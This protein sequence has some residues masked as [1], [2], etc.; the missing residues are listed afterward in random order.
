MTPSTEQT[1]L[2][3]G[4]WVLALDTPTLPPAT[5]TNTLIVGGDRL[6]I[7]E[8]ATPHAREQAR[9]DSL[10]ATLRAEGRELAGVLVTHH[11]VDHVGYAEGLRDAHGIPIYAH[12][13]TASRVDFAVDHELE[14]DWTIDLGD[15][16]T[17]ETIH[18]PG[19]APGHVVVWDQKTG[20]VHAGDLVAGQ[21]TILI[22]VSD[23][24]D[25]AVYLD[26]LRRMAA[27]VGA[28]APGSIRFVPA[29][30]PVLDDPLAV[31]EHYIR[32]RLAREAKVRAAVVEAGHRA[33]M[34]IFAAAYADT[35][36]RLWPFAALSLEAHL[37][38]LVAD[39]ELT[40]DGRGAKPV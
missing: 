3:E 34:T 40:R 37:R 36:K 27:K 17:V 22:D 6:L 10:L 7:I 28:E 16:H 33:F 26:S 32:H 23:D 2:A 35:P 30:G 5:T 39:G 15:G 20:I 19:H 8:P 9:L 38:K 14:E 13:Q 11:H 25:M 12:A 24:G 21:G 29:H 4:A 1:R 18:T 31:L